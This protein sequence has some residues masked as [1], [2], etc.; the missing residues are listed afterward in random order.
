MAAFHAGSGQVTR[1]RGPE[2]LARTTGQVPGDG[3]G[4]SPG[5]TRAPSLGGR[6][7]SLK[8]WPKGKFTTPNPQA[9]VHGSDLFTPSLL[10]T[11]VK[12]DWHL[13]EKRKRPWA[14]GV[15]R[16]AR[17]DAEPKGPSKLQRDHGRARVSG[18]GRGS[19]RRETWSPRASILPLS[20]ARLNNLVLRPG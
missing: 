15:G 10:E 20:H 17:G 16:R 5:P 7:T 19:W 8:G 3:G 9:R 11:R 18:W 1:G 12:R 13:L 6:S 2:K 14:H 4:G